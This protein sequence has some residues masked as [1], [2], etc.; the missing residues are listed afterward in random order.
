MFRPSPLSTSFFAFPG[1]TLD[2]GVRDG[3]AEEL[4]LE[5]VAL[6]SSCPAMALAGGRPPTSADGGRTE[7]RGLGG[8]SIQASDLNTLD[9][10]LYSFNVS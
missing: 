7:L 9:P 8:S 3:E 1:D 5:V 4:A 2:N 6:N 10:S